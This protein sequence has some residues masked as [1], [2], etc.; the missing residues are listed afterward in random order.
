MLVDKGARSAYLRE[1]ERQVS[2]LHSSGWLEAE[3][4][5]IGDAIRGDAQRDGEQW[6]MGNMDE[7]L[8]ALVQQ[9]KDRR[10]ILNENYGL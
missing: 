6:G 8:E 10:A 9:M 1:L 7:G 3:A 4:R 5:A 2:V